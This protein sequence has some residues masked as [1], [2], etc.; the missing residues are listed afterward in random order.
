M[1]DWHFVLCTVSESESGGDGTDCLRCRA[2]GIS[3][4]GRGAFDGNSTLKMRCLIA[5]KDDYSWKCS[6]CSW[7]FVGEKTLPHVANI[8]E[9]LE[10]YRQ[11]IDE[12]FD[13]HDC[14]KYQ[15]RS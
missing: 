1:C 13:A 5:G 10:L 8:Q 7:K 6:Q 11:E 12:Q 9:L 14:S 15:K 2:V 4:A 3:V